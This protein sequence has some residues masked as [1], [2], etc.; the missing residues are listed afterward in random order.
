M[1]ITI[2]SHTHTYGFNVLH[3]ETGSTLNHIY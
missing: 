3:S 2:Q 1:L